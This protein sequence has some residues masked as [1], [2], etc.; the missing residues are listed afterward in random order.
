MASSFPARLS[1]E[2]N[3][4]CE[5]DAGRLTGSPGDVSGWNLEAREW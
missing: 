4:G 2:K 3:A 1:R 5:I